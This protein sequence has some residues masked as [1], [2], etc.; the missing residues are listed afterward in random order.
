[1]KQKGFIGRLKKAMYG[2]RSAPRMWQKVVKQTMTDMG[3]SSCI[4]TPCLYYHQARDIFVVA[5]VDDFLCS[6]KVA[7]IQW[8][9]TELEKKFGLTS[10][11]IGPGQSGNYLGRKILWEVDG[12]SIEGE[13]KYIDTMIL[14][15]DLANSSGLS[16]PGCNEDKREAGGDEELR[17]RLTTAFRRSAAMANYMAQDRPDISFASKEVSRGMSCP[18]RLDTVKL[19]RMIRYL[20]NARRRAIK[21]TWQDPTDQL[22]VFSDS[23]WAGCVKTRRSTSGGVLLHGRHLVHHWSS[24]QATVALSSA[25]AELNAIVKGMA[26]VIGA[27]SMVE[28]CFRSCRGRIFTD[29]SAANGIVHREGCG[30]VKHLE[31]RQLWIQGMVGSGKVTCLKVPRA[32]N[33]ADAMTHYWNCTDG[34]NHFK[35]IGLVVPECS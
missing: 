16:T 21:Y 27:K 2:T 10:Q 30:K 19:K 1:M 4:T 11:I 20:S 5:H 8:M 28:E 31:C 6:G 24:T 18:T 22:T 26:E 25:E 17:P 15:W 23:D 35:K 3:F 13:N 33:P 29:S 9:K 34:S 14:E 32:D 12:I 7:D